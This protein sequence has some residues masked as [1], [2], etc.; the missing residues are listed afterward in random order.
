MLIACGA[1][2]ALMA[3]PA[4]AQGAPAT[5]YVRLGKLMADPPEGVGDLGAAIRQ[6]DTALRPQVEQIKLLE[7]ELDRLQQRQREA[8]QSA[9]PQGAATVQNVALQTESAGGSD[10][11]ELTEET[12]RVREQLVAKRNQLHADYEVQRQALLAP[13]QSRVNARAQVFASRNGCSQLKMAR[14]SDLAA[15][16]A[17]AARDVTGEFVAWYAQNKS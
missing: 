12:Q 4:L 3:P 10:L 13:V 2:L 1:A 8:M 14:T 17:A 15:L 6:L 7:A 5:C 16:Q 9:S 11:G